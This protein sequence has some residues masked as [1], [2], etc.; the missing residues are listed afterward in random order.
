MNQEPQSHVKSDVQQQQ[1]QM[2]NMN[3]AVF[4]QENQLVNDP[5]KIVGNSSTMGYQQVVG[6]CQTPPTTTT[7]PSQHLASA[8]QST[9]LN[10][11]PQQQQQQQQTQV[12]IKRF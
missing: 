1:F 5:S 7:A 3:A 4:Q 9:T 2:N 8:T 11:L 12:I 6:V 10:N